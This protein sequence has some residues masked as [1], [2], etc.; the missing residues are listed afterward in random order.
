MDNMHELTFDILFL[1]VGGLKYNNI[2]NNSSKKC[3]LIICAVTLYV[4]IKMLKQLKS[5]TRDPDAAVIL[6]V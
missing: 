6:F 5:L 1:Y 2:T 3:P 4:K